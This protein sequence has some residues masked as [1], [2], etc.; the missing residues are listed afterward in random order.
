MHFWWRVTICAWQTIV[1]VRHLTKW[2]FNQIDNCL[3][4]GDPIHH[5]TFIV[6]R[7]FIVTDII[8][9]S[10]P[11]TWWIYFMYLFERNGH[12]KWAKENLYVYECNAC[13][14]ILYRT[15]YERLYYTPR[16]HLYLYTY[17][18]H[19][20]THSL[21]W[22]IQHGYCQ[23]TR[24]I[25]NKKCESSSQEKINKHSPVNTIL[26]IGFVCP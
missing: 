14:I 7:L 18:K 6:Y 26:Y 12:L 2:Y 15:I 8:N 22:Y 3:Q 13:F 21:A 4:M 5:V 20:L 16:M 9:N 1:R 19:S 24:R 17:T 11:K 23:L 10:T 25:W